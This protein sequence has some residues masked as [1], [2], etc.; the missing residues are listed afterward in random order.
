MS[1]AIT[2]VVWLAFIIL[3]FLPTIVALNRHLPWTTAIII[4]NVLLG[5]TVLGWVGAL[6]WSAMPVPARSN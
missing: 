3:Y 4:L 6:V 1:D 2:G 5:W